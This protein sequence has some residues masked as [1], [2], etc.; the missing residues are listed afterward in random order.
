MTAR[1]MRALAWTIL[2]VA[3]AVPALVRSAAGREWTDNTGTFKVEAEYVGFKDGNVHLRKANG[4][5]IAVPLRRLSKSDQELVETRRAGATAADPGG[6]PPAGEIDWSRPDAA[7]QGLTGAVTAGRPQVVWQALPPSHQQQVT[8]LVHTYAEAMD[9][10]VWNKGFELGQKVVALLRS[11]REL[12]FASQMTKQMANDT[13]VDLQKAS[14]EWEV[15]VGLFETIVNSE[16]SDLDQLKTLDVERFLS[17]TGAKFASQL[18]E[19]AE[20]SKNP[21]ELETLRTA[22]FEVAEMDGDTALL[23]FV[24]TDGDGGQIETTVEMKKVEGRWLPAGLVDGLPQ[25]VAMAKAQVAQVSGEQF[26]ESKPDILAA[27]DQVGAVL[28]QLEAAESQEDF[29]KVLQGAIGPLLGPLMG[30]PADDPFG[31]D[32]GGDPFGEKPGGDPFGKEKPDADPSGKKDD[33][34]GG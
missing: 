9:K 1:S 28:D 15:V 25:A 11:K 14:R 34:F 8:E 33:P 16:L 22:Q 3:V 12:L 20:L 5:T 6:V 21:S 27:M 17:G 29:D 26:A 10:D 32:G 31:E 13:P 2:V 24:R 4:I 30:G 7:L 19:V 18:V 23:K